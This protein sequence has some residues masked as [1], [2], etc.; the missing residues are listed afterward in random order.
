ML[1]LSYDESP[2]SGGVTLGY[3]GG[4]AL[5]AMTPFGMGPNTSHVPTYR[6]RLSGN[7]VVYARDPGCPPLIRGSRV[8]FM[9]QPDGSCRIVPEYRR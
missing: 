6:I 3:L 9:P 5:G 1:G 7:R 8:I 4:V 2:G